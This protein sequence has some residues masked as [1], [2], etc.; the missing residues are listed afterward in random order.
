[1]PKYLKSVRLYLYKNQ[2]PRLDTVPPYAKLATVTEKNIK[3]VM[4]KTDVNSTAPILL[5]LSHDINR[6]LKGTPAKT[7]FHTH[8]IDNSK[9]LF[10]ISDLLASILNKNGSSY[11]TG[12]ESN[13]LRSVAIAGSMFSSEIIA[14]VQAI[15]TSETTRY[16]ES[17]IKTYLSV[18]KF[19]KGRFG[20][21]Q[22]S[23]AEDQNRPAECSRP[24]CKYYL[25][26]NPPTTN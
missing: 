17:T 12:V 18:A 13:A 9:S 25:V 22:L 21:I 15:F 14:Q 23:N 8:Y 19:H 7:V 5:E 1:M 16:P 20:K 26:V 6:M 11:E 24:R 3:N 4:T 2:F 10:G